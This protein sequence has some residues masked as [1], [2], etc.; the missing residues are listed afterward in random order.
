[1]RR[2]NYY[3]ITCL[4]VTVQKIAATWKSE[5]S[6]DVMGVVCIEFYSDKTELRE[7]VYQRF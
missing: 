4:G 6:H 1:M 2:Y 7:Q 3:T 5:S